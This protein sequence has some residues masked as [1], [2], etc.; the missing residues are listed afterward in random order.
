MDWFVA[1]GSISAA[2]LRAMPRQRRL[3]P[4]LRVMY[5]NIIREAAAG[6][7]LYVAPML[8]RGM[9]SHGGVSDAFREFLG[10]Y[11]TTPPGMPLDLD[12]VPL[13]QVVN[14]RLSYRDLTEEEMARM[15]EFME[16]VKTQL[17]ARLPGCTI[18]P[19]Y[20]ETKT[21]HDVVFGTREGVVLRSATLTV[22]W[23]A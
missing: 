7:S 9:C 22:T 3:Q 21:R 4:L 2:Q 23:K 10:V 1:L 14:L 6:K 8:D 16:L 18:I 5:E 17:G 12:K 11:M 19:V 13:D 15:P 20:T